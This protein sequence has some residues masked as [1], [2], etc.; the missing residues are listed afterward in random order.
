MA[1]FHSLL[2]MIPPDDVPALVQAAITSH[3]GLAG[4]IVQ[5]ATDRVPEEAT[6]IYDAA[7]SVVAGVPFSTSIS[8]FR[9]E[10]NLASGLKNDGQVAPE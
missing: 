4:P 5:L 8:R 6:R 10:K 9:R 2:A 3:P 7:E 1:I